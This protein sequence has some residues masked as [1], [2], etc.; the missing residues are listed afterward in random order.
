MR[1]IKSEITSRQAIGDDGGKSRKNRRRID[2][3]S[4]RRSCK[5]FIYLL[6]TREEERERAADS[7]GKVSDIFPEIFSEFL[8]FEIFGLSGLKLGRSVKSLLADLFGSG[9]NFSDFF[10]LE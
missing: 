3:D 5:L 1:V 7:A 8:I 2:A 6:L 4:R 9:K 10:R